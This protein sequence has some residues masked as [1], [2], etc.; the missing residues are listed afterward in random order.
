[1]HFPGVYAILYRRSDVSELCFRRDTESCHQ[2]Y[3]FYQYTINHTNICFRL[4]FWYI[5]RH[6][7]S[8]GIHRS[9]GYCVVWTRIMRI[10]SLNIDLIIKKQSSQWFLITSLYVDHKVR[11][12]GRLADIVTVVRSCYAIVCTILVSGSM[13][14]ANLHMHINVEEMRGKS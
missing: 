12:R 8:P 2:L 13:L 10:I 1:M 5:I 6:R 3:R 14:N 4:A 11:D 7:W 9:A